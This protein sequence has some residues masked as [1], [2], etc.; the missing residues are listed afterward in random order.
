MFRKEDE[1]PDNFKYHNIMNRYL[2]VN[3]W[4]KFSNKKSQIR[5]S[6]II[7]ID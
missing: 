5:E 1:I 3:S 7:Y 2:T 6:H 4:K